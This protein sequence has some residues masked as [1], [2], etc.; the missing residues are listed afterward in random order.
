MG[1]SVGPEE[2][3]RVRWGWLLGG[4]A[5]LASA[6]AWVA[7]RRPPASSGLPGEVKH[8]RWQDWN[9]RYQV[10][11]SGPP[12]LLIHGIGAGVHSYEWRHNFLPLAQGHR[13][14]AL[15]LLGAGFSSKPAI[16]YSAALMAGL[17]QDFVGEVVG[18][19]VDAVAA[20]ESTGFLVVAADQQPEQFKRLILSNPAPVDGRRH[21][22]GPAI[23]ALG[24]GMTLPMIGQALLNAISSQQ[25]ITGYLQDKI[26][27]RYLPSPVE[28]AHYY[29]IAHLPQAR[30]L[31]AAF[32]KGDLDVDLRAVYPRLRQPILLT[33]GL[34]AEWSPLSDSDAFVHLNP[35][36]R[37]EV[38]EQSGLCPYVEEAGRFNALLDGFLATAQVA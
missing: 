2:E 7:W 21:V 34:H 25:A 10:A 16:R 32:L 3:V 14:Y 11:G 30:H 4:L 24:W 5:A 13:V 35:N 9:I 23:D 18:S 17:L 8:F 6:N 31:I 38:F 20:S 37:L 36:S 28:A 1:P 15:D 27:H 33:W 26:Y 22:Q 29:A 19:P 12:L